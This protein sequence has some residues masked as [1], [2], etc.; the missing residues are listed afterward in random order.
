MNE[1]KRKIGL[2]LIVG[3]LGIVYGDIGTSPLYAMSEAFFGH[4]PLAGS[5][6]NV[7]G[8]LSLVFWSLFLV[9][10]LKY[11]MLVLRADNQGEGGIFALLGLFLKKERAHKPGTPG[12]LPT[13]VRP[14]L[15]AAILVGAALLHGES[16]ITPAISVLSAVEGLKLIAPA[17]ERIQIPVT[18][19]ILV[20]L[21]A[22]Q[23]KGTHR[24]GAVFG[25]FMAVWFLTIA[26]LGVAQIVQ[27]PAVLE[28][29]SPHHAVALARTHGWQVVLVLGAVVLCITG[30]EALYADLGHFN[31][32]AISRSWLFL[33]FPALLLNY[34]GQG[35][36]MLSGRPVPGNHLFYALVPQPLL[37]PMVL[38]ATG[39]TI[40]A[41]QALISGIFSLNQQATA[42]GLFPRL[43]I[44]H[45]NPDVPGQIYVPFVNALLLGGCVWLV[46]SFRSSG[47]LAAAY[48]IAVTGTMTITTLSFTLVAITVFGW[49]KRYVLPV[50]A[51]ILGVDLAFFGANLLKFSS[52]GYVPVL[53][54]FL[55]FVVMDTWRWGRAWIGRAYGERLHDVHMTLE[56][57]VE[58][59]PRYLDAHASVSLVVMASRPLTD[60]KDTVPPVLSI[61]YRNWKRLPK[62]LIFL[63]IQQLGQPWVDEDA[64]YQ[65]KVFTADEHGTVVAVQAFY[66]YMEQPNVR[67]A[68]LHL[69]QSRIVK[70][71]QDPAR[72]LILLGAERFVSHGKNLPER[73][74]L[75]LFSRLNRLA[76]PVTDYFGLERDSAVTVETINV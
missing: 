51:V 9:V 45:T 73:L 65:A 76:K 40:I 47:A 30:V 14:A 74:R 55:V 13:W 21:F 11:V 61:H 36:Y 37:I 12:A 22:V 46:L 54:G 29:L 34:L 58:Q 69:K 24:I 57:I 52:G 25:P 33:V 10:T 60:L 53:I 3:S 23:R 18:I 59:K 8:V 39:A 63:S 5:R 42:L 67:E 48:G 49:P 17:A 4:Y 27:H 19:V 43:K 50:M 16:V 75:G 68:L 38:L 32:G 15:V 26:A 2:G 1:R 7:L 62:H 71:P 72:W 35:A 28:A 20:L 31:R 70:I 64:R 6:E 41:S 56:T 44:V 66:G